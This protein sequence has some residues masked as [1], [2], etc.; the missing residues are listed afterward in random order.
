MI[1]CEQCLC[2]DDADYPRSNAIESKQQPERC[3]KLILDSPLGTRKGVQNLGVALAKADGGMRLIG[4]R[5]T[6]ELFN[7][8]WISEVLNSLVPW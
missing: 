3:A 7:Q 5:A 8:H 6:A 2:F 1:Q 4:Q